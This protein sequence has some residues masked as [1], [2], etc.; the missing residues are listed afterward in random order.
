MHSE[1]HRVLAFLSAIGL[2]ELANSILLDEVVHNEM[3]G[4][5]SA[6]CSGSDS[7]A[8]GP[9]FDTRSCHFLAFLL[10]L[11]Q[12]QLSLAGESMCT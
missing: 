4:P 9:G 2:A 3:A 10:P 12:G 7:R 6:G 5:H 11:I 8:R 1:L